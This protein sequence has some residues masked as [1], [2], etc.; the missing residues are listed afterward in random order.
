VNDPFEPSIVS[1]LGRGPA[2]VGAGCII[3]DQHVVT[4]AHVVATAIGYDEYAAA[5]PT[6]PVPIEF[7]FSK[8]GDAATVETWWPVARTGY[9]PRDGRAD[10]ALLALS[11]PLPSGAKPARLAESD[12][13][14]HQNFIAFGF[15]VG[16]PLGVEAGGVCGGRRL[17]GRIQVQTQTGF[18]IEPGFSGSPVWIEAYEAVGGILV[19][20]IVN[21]AVAPLAFVIPASVLVA[22]CPSARALN[23]M[24][25]RVLW[26]PDPPPGY[27]S[28]PELLAELKATLFAASATVAVSGVARRGALQGMGG[29]GKTVLASAL[30]RDDEVRHAFPD[31]IYWLTLG[32]HSNVVA[33]QSQLA[34]E[35]SKQPEGFLDSQAGKAR[36]EELL[37]EKR[38]LVILDDVWSVADARAFDFRNIPTQL[39]FTTRDSR[40]VEA[41]G[42]AEI[43]VPLL[44]DVQARDVLASFSGQAVETLPKEAADVIDAANGVPLALA[45][46]GRLTQHRPEAWAEALRQLQ[47]A[48]LAAPRGREADFP[49]ESVARAIE[50]SVA[51]MQPDARELFFDLAVFPEDAPI[52]LQVLES[53]WAERGLTPL[54]VANQAEDFVARSLASWH[55]EREGGQ[56]NDRLILHDLVCGYLRAQVVN[57]AERQR[58]LLQANLPKSGKWADLPAQDTYLWTWLSYHLAEAGWKDRL[59]TLLFDPEWIRRKLKGA[60]V[61]ALIGD[62]RLLATDWEAS[63]LEAALTLSAHVL[64]PGPDHVAAQ[65]CGRL[66]EE[67]GPCCAGL[68]IALRKTHPVLFAPLRGGYLIHP[69]PLLR[70]IP[71]ANEVTAVAVLADGHS[72]LAGSRDKTLWLWDIETGAEICRFEGHHHWVSVVAVL[73]EHRVLSGSNDGTLRL[74]NLQ[75]GAELRRFEGHEDAVTALA[76][77][78]G[79]HALSGS[80]DGTLRLWNL[81]T[82]AE[83]RRFRG[84]NSWVRAIALMPN[85]QRALSAQDKT[86]RLWDLKTGTE[87]RQ[88]AGHQDRVRALAVLPDGRRVLSGSAD[89]TLLLWDVETGAELQR[90]EGHD[91]WV[92]AVAMRWDGRLALSGSQDK[93]LR[94]W[95]V[96]T[97]SELRRFDGHEDAVRAVALMPDGHRALSGS[98]DKTLRLWDVETGTELRRFAGYQAG[99]RALAVLADGRRVL[100][101][102]ADGALWLWDVETGTELQRFEGHRD[103]VRALAVRSDG[104]CA[105]SGS[106]DMTLRLWDVETGAELRQFEG[107]GSSVRGVALLG[108]GRRALSGSAVGKLRLWDL[109]TGAELACFVGDDTITA[110]DVSLA[111]NRA[112]VGDARGRVMAFNVAPK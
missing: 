103:A 26:V 48:R 7:V 66:V 62:Y 98:E 78:D 28:R 72:A 11:Q 40:V 99:V 68:L 107:D 14:R 10:L 57:H 65:L 81:E 19:E 41:V 2:P 90:F 21:R 104:Q 32:Q 17:D 53:F 100:S 43:R 16:Q 60:G 92:L 56:R 87:L 67:D 30:A 95:D 9:E 77:L 59:K 27:V 73:D 35:L 94:L 29:I 22:I 37:S 36:L 3:T 13:L 89:G 50:A 111:G 84:L 110:I 64:G 74:W 5:E 25:G 55:E 51:A 12:N 31:G 23:T 47:N 102:S 6:E 70:T 109:I 86:L 106:D 24:L 76:V 46:A 82:G 80:A 108:N 20:R 42:A 33:R 4:C 83:Q 96:E 39:L 61:N 38:A 71:V 105:L 34:H 91:D 49:Y 58:Q 75:T 18:P 45:M 15:P 88:F 44:S 1:I 85:G 79:R 69:G 8:G 97:G 54:A 63:R 93:T 112:I 101:G 52:P